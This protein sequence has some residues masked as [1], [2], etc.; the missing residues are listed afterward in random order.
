L[1][2][3]YFFRVLNLKIIKGVLSNVMRITR[4]Q[5]DENYTSG[6]EIFEETTW[7]Y[8]S[9]LLENGPLNFLLSTSNLSEFK[10]NFHYF[11]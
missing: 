9:N 11:T 7:K 5:N 4:D 6:Y 8:T 1:P 2:I 3:E 10:A